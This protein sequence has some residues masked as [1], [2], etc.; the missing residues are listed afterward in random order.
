[1]TLKRWKCSIKEQL[2][3]CGAASLEVAQHDVKLVGIIAGLDFK[4]SLNEDVTRSVL[5]SIGRKL[6]IDLETSVVSGGN[7]GVAQVLTEA[8]HHHRV[9]YFPERS[10]GNSTG[11]YFV[12]SSETARSNDPKDEQPLKSRSTYAPAQALGHGYAARL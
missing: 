9:S 3:K 10:F 7:T 5:S 11:V 12:M 6:A 1:M 4:F 2:K 8:F